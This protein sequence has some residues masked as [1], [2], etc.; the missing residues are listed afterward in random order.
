VV[1]RRGLDEVRPFSDVEALVAGRTPAAAWQERCAALGIG[2]VP[3]GVEPA[4]AKD[5]THD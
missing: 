3:L 2:A 5:G 4:T 1:L